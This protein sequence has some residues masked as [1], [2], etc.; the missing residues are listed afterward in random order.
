MPAGSSASKAAGDRVAWV[1]GAQALFAGDGAEYN[2]ACYCGDA[3]FLDWP[4][5]LDRMA[6]FDPVA[7]IPGRGRPL[8]TRA[9]TQEALALTRQ[10]LV[11]HYQLAAAAAARGAPLMEEFLATSEIC[12]PKYGDYAIYEHC[13]P[14]NVSRGYDEPVGI[15]TPRIWTAARDLALWKELQGD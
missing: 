12:D 10:F 3:H 15:D 11:D 8:T 4:A 7:L 1:T 13:L 9:E 6:S 14:F 2:S 5:T